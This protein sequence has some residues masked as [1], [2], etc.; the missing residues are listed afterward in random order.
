MEAGAPAGVF[1][2]IQGAAEVGA[3]LITDA[4]VAK[5]SLTGSVP[6]GRK[7]YAA[8]AEGLKHATMELGGKSPLIIFEDADIEDAV[9]ARDQREF[10]LDRAGLF[11][12]HTGLRAS[13]PVGGVP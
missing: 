9:S 8:A 11:E 3:A 1:N 4:R 13:R 6:T 5:V 2:V 12:R 10:L 7:V